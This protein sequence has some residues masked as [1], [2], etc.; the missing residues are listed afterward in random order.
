[1]LAIEIF[2]NR[3]QNAPVKPCRSKRFKNN[4]TS[5]TTRFLSKPHLHLWM[6]LAR[7][8]IGLECF[9]RRTENPRGPQTYHPLIEVF[10]WNRDWS[11]SRKWNWKKDTRFF[12][13]KCWKWKKWLSACVGDRTGVIRGTIYRNPKCHYTLNLGFYNP[14]ERKFEMAQILGR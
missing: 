13:T 6:P 12:S 4:S 9:F 3:F 1:L 14:N 11:E 10:F 5:L 2:P 8:L 7:S